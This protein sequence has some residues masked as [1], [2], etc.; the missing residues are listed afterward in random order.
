[1]SSLFRSIFRRPI[2]VEGLSEVVFVVSPMSVAYHVLG[3]C[4]GRH[5][6]VRLRWTGNDLLWSEL[7]SACVRGHLA[8]GSNS[9]NSYR[10]R[11]LSDLLHKPRRMTRSEILLSTTNAYRFMMKRHQNIP[12]LAPTTSIVSALSNSALTRFFGN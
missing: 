3:W 6:R 9:S 7:R 2:D 1:M 4:A 10:S 5:R 12:Y 11:C 8:N